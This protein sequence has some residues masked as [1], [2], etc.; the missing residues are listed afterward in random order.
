MFHSRKLNNRINQIREKALRLVYKDYSITFDALLFKVSTKLQ[1]LAVEIFKVKLGLAPEVMKNVFP[2]IENPYNLKKAT[3]F[4]SRNVKTDR[5]G[6]KNASFV[7]P[8]VSVF[9]VMGLSRILCYRVSV[10]C[11][12]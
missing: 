4:K 5:N 8:R 10:F 2:I 7:V 11:A 3:K 1:K 9:W 6:I 12:V